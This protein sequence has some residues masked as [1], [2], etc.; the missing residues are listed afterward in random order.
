[1]AAETQG[2]VLLL[3]ASRALADPLRHAG[4][5]HVELLEA[6]GPLEALA[7]LRREAID[8]VVT[9]RATSIEEDLACV[10]EARVARP[11]VR[12]VLV[13]P[14]T[15]PDE[16]IRALRA[17]A[18]AC[19]T[20]PVAVDD[21]AS[22]LRRA[23]READWH[24]G[25][26]V[27]SAKPE[28]I[29]LRVNCRL[30]TAERVVGFL[31]ELR[32]ELTPEVREEVAYAFR[33]ILIN[34]MEHGGRFDP[35]QVVEVA[36]VRTKRTVVYY[37]RDPGSG[38]QAGG[39]GHAA[40]DGDVDPLAHDAARAAQGLRPGGFGLLIVKNVVDEVIF[41]ENGNEVLLIKHLR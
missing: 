11:G 25:I 1:M 39:L 31:R 33:E 7:R 5:E 10:E 38:F 32:S 9:D 16:V 14:R 13:A 41:S 6:A 35:N 40:V 30:L 36:A 37:V 21:L 15:T 3:G 18:F 8:A 23:L 24:D 29:S 26:E 19:F 28:W 12:L 27:V 2:L 34:A 22:L 17:R 20:D 4:L